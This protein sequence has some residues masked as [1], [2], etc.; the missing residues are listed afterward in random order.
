MKNIKSYSEF[1]EINESKI[2]KFED[3]G[4]IEE[5]QVD[6]EQTGNVAVVED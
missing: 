3:F 1:T 4:K 2:L 6:L 5:K